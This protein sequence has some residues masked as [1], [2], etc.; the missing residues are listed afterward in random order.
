M[1]LATIN[2]PKQLLHLSFIGHVRAEELAHSREDLPALLASLSPGF[3]LVTDLGRLDSIDADCVTEIGQAMELCGQK[4]VGL[5]IRV[6]PDPTKD[7]G[8]NIIS[9]FH[10][11][12]RP[13]VV[14]CNSIVEAAKFLSL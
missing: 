10:Y 13:R 11:A 14:T 6:I 12:N 8:L 3:K 7:I 9:Q 2:Q 1:I 4:G 5:V